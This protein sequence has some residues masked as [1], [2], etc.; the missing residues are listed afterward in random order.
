MNSLLDVEPLRNL[1]LNLST[2]YV[3]KQFI[4]NTSSGERVLD[5]YLVNDLRISYTIYPQFFRKVGLQLL[6]A[7]LLNKEY[8]TNAWIYRYHTEGTEQSVDGYFPQA[9]IHLMAGIRVNF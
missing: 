6:V 3:G 2:R 8:E 5:P 9:G 4:D 7:N 1:H